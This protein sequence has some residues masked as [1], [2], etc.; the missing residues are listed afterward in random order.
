MA[1]SNFVPGKKLTTLGIST[2]TK[3]AWVR[4]GLPVAT[5]LIAA[6]WYFI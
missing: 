1:T 3:S 4:W 5:G 2:P 6:L